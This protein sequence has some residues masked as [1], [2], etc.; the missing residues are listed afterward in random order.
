MT[1]TAKYETNKRNMKYATI[2]NVINSYQ[3][4]VTGCLLLGQGHS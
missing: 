1:R 4:K 2:S 3:I